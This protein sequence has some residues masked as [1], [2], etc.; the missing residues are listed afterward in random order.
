VIDLSYLSQFETTDGKKLGAKI[1]LK[2]VQY[3]YNEDRTIM[4]VLDWQVDKIHTDRYGWDITEKSFAVACTALLLDVTWSKHLIL[5]HLFFSSLIT[6]DMIS[7]LPKDSRYRR[8]LAPFFN[9]SRSLLYDE[10]SYLTSS[11]SGE[12]LR[13]SGLTQKGMLDFFG[14]CREQFDIEYEYQLAKFLH[15]EYMVIYEEFV[16]NLVGDADDLQLNLPH[17]PNSL[18]PQQLVVLLIY[19][20]STKHKIIGTS[21]LTLL[22][23]LALQVDD[24]TGEIYRNDLIYT[25]STAYGTFY[26]FKAMLQDDFLYLCETLDERKA[27]LQFRKRIFEFDAIQR[28]RDPDNPNESYATELDSSCM[29]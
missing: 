1:V 2:D 18:S 10:I 19:M 27:Y 23:Y 24:M 26:N 22:P 29:R 3:E 6:A 9:D 25:L 14:Y 17:F 16:Q 13:T 11:P 8:L 28:K 20:V 21:V 15:N 7:C 12:I 4:T 5:C